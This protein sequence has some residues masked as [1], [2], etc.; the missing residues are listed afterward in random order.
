MKMVLVVCPEGRETEFRDSIEKRGIHAYTEIRHAIGEGKT[1][2]RLGTH[3]WPGESVII[4]MVIDDD[5]K[6]EIEHV[7]RQSDDV[8]GDHD[9]RIERAV[10]VAHRVHVATLA[11]IAENDW[12]LNIPR[13]VA[14]PL[15]DDIPTVA[16]ALADLKAALRDAYAAEDRLKGLLEE[17]GLLSERDDQEAP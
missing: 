15:Q 5:K 3:I 7:V 16:E 12:N 4:F 10:A 1:G 9:R 6:A 11:E 13:Y 14:P 2:K 17:A 8:G